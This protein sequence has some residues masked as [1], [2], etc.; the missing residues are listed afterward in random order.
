MNEFTDH[1]EKLDK[2]VEDCNAELRQR[3]F[4]VCEAM[5]SGDY[6]GRAVLRVLAPTTAKNP[7]GGVVF[8]EGGGLLPLPWRMENPPDI[9]E[10]LSDAL[11]TAETVFVDVCAKNKALRISFD[12]FA[13]KQSR[14]IET[15]TQVP[16]NGR[17]KLVTP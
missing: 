12:G 9:P 8:L 3:G 14:T 5:V 4:H 13:R 10:I 2:Y 15:A 7:M 17:L 16:E 11:K 1:H 6:Q